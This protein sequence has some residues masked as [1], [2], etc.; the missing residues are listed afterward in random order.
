MR[1]MAGISV[2]EKRTVTVRTT[3][4]QEIVEGDM[5]LLRVRGQDVVCTFKGMDGRGYFMTSPAT[6]GVAKSVVM[7]RP[8]SIDRCHKVISLIIDEPVAGI[9]EDLRA[10][11]ALKEGRPETA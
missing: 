10:A 2:E 3:D 11:A 7:Y 9:P 1:Q 8:G 4:G 5:L 6:A